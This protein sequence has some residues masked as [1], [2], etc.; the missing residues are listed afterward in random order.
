MEKEKWKHS[1]NQIINFIENKIKVLEKKN[2]EDSQNVL[3][4]IFQLENEINSFSE[5]IDRLISKK[6]IY[7]FNIAEQKKYRELIIQIKDKIDKNKL[8][9]ETISQT[10]KEIN[11][12]LP[13]MKKI[14][15]K[16]IQ[17]KNDNLI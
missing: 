10:L 3:N 15:N 9:K 6:V 8:E 14:I 4:N 17:T 2:I 16:P 12:A 13:Y 1:E 5:K 7:E 11:N